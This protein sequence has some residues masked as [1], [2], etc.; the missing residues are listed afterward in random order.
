M[1]EGTNVSSVPFADFENSASQRARQKARRSLL[2]D[3][4]SR[5]GDAMTKPA[6]AE[7]I[8]K[9]IL[10]VSLYN[11]VIIAL[12]SSSVNFNRWVREHMYILANAVKVHI[13]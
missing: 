10:K 11:F 2:S 5:L 1:S 12:P 4:I 9:Q 8:R 13:W 3:R 6:L 7:V